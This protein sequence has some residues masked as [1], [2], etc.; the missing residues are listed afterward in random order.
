MK[1]AAEQFESD[2]RVYDHDEHNEEGDVQQWK[3]RFHDG[4][5][6]HLKTCDTQTRAVISR[7]SGQEEQLSPSDRAMRLASS[8]LTNYN[9]T[10]QKLLVRQVLTKPTVWSWRFSWRQCVINKPRTVELCNVY[11]TFVPTTC[12][13]A[14]L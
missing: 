5:Q 10:V 9:A 6:H 14:I 1:L 13:G 11:I 3:H 12:C 2:D 8:N 4:V 7:Y